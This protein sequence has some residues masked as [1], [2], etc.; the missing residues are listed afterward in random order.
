MA[1]SSE[2]PPIAYPKVP[3]SAGKVASWLTTVDHKRIGIL[4]ISTALVYFVAGGIL[5]L[6]IRWQLATP[7]S[8]VFARD[9]YNQ[10]FTMHGTTMI[11]L[12]VVPILAG[13]ANYLVPLMIGARDMAFPRLNAL[14]YWLY[15]LGGIVLYSSWFASHG[16]PRAGWYS[17]PPVSTYSQGAGQDLWILAI[18]ILTISSVA[19]AI[20]FLVTIHNLR[21]RGMRW[22]RL[23][24]FVWTVEVFSWLLIVA[25]P[26]LSA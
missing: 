23:P 22:T 13:F 18:H 15:A 4:Y 12:V 16:A 17:Y 6:M 24:L 11:F 3:W 8:D 2:T 25:L 14:S 9:T 10:L 5:A 1:A 7:D 21:T 20:N 19:G 26:S